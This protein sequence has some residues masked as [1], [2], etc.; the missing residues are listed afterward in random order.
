MGIVFQSYRNEK[1]NIPLYASLTHSSCEL[2]KDCEGSPRIP[3]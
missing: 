2:R 3:L 1:Q